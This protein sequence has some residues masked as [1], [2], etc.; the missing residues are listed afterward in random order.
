MVAGLDTPHPTSHTTEQDRLCRLRLIRSRRV[1]P[2]TYHR[3][4]AEHGSAEAAL[5]ALPGIARASGVEGYDPCPEAVA[6]AEMRAARAVGA[7]V[8]D[9]GGVEHGRS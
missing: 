8:L 3:L 4:V 9:L 2:A 7:A 5:E 1:G 6:M